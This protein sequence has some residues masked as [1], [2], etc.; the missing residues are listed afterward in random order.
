MPTQG[1]PRHSRLRKITEPFLLVQIVFLIALFKG[2]VHVTIA[3]MTDIMAIGVKVVEV[4]IGI[5]G[6]IGIDTR[7]AID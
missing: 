1:H 5:D 2:T 3:I 6:L 7:N 4:L